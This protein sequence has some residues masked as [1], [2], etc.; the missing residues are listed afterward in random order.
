MDEEV[1]K[2]TIVVLVI[3]TVI[4]SVLGTWTVFNEASKVRVVTPVV[5]PKENYQTTGKVSVTIDGPKETFIGGT[6]K[7]TI[8]IKDKE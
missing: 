1:S 5:L 6:G 4:I 8:A 7:V 3:L 2:N